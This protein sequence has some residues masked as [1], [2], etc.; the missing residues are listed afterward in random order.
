MSDRITPADWIESRVDD[1]AS[2]AFAGM[3][4]D[5]F[6]DARFGERG[7]RHALEDQRHHLR[8]LI[9][10]LRLERPEMME[11]YARW[12]QVVLTSRGMCS[13]HL[14]DNFTLLATLVESE[15]P[16]SVDPA[17]HYLEDAIQALIYADGPAGAVHETM[18][19]LIDRTELRL[20]TAE[21]TGPR[22]SADLR[23]RSRNDLAHMLSYLADALALGK[24][25]LFVGHVRWA[26]GFLTGLGLPDHYLREQL[27]AIDQ[28]L[29]ELGIPHGAE[30]HATLRAGI[31][32]VLENPP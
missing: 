17:R 20:F 4:R 14:A 15:N 7:R 9:L 16:A 27:V 12:L 32:V 18:E 11:E 26:H 19:P 25:D 22:V 31:D 24:P 29:A 5:P 21:R 10:A 13:R 2:R 23:S 28:A 6:W 30:I 3:Y 8:H 1:L